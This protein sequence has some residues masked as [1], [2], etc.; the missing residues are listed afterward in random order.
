M[1][2]CCT[3]TGSQG[4]SLPLSLPSSL[5]PCWDIFDTLALKYVVEAVLELLIVLPPLPKSWVFG[6]C[7]CWASQDVSHLLMRTFTS[8]FRECYMNLALVLQRSGHQR[9]TSGPDWTFVPHARW[10]LRACF[11]LL[12][13]A[14]SVT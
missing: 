6:M 10:D 9:Y 7:H 12:G 14:L 3:L 5:P 2:A 4:I 11:S 8:Q 1:A 13:L